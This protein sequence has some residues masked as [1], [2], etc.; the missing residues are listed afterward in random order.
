MGESLKATLSGQWSSLSKGAVY[1]MGV[2][3]LAD[4]DLAS[5]GGDCVLGELL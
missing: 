3:E 4:G 2:E 1:Y 5:D